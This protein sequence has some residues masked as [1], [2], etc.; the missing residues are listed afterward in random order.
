M[1]Y[2]LCLLAVGGVLF[3][4]A[5]GEDRRT[6]LLATLVFGV[7]FVCVLVAFLVEA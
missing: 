1:I 5:Y 4:G 3:R 7:Y 2:L 6:K